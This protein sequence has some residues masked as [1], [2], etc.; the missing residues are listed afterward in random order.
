MKLINLGLLNLNRKKIKTK[1]LSFS[2]HNSL[3]HIKME[4]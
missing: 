4:T 3:N 2:Y 1:I